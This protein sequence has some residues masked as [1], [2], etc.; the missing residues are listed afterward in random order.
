MGVLTIC[1]FGCGLAATRP[2]LE[3]GL[4]ATA[5]LAAKEVNANVLSPNLFRKAEVYYIKAKSSYRRKY[6]NKAKE[7]A[8]LSRK[9]SEKAEFLAIKK[10]TIEGTNVQ[11]I[12]E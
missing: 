12:A 10:A 3:M 9:Y 2:K 8:D 5:F 11:S 6:F 7:Y 1:L 4:A